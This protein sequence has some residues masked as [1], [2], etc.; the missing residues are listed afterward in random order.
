MAHRRDYHSPQRNLRHRPPRRKGIFHGF[1]VEDAESRAHLTLD[2]IV[3]GSDTAVNFEYDTFWEERRLLELVQDHLDWG[4]RTDTPF[5]S[6]YGDWGRAYREAERRVRAGKID[7]V[8]HEILINHGSEGEV[9]FRLVPKLMSTLGAEIPDKAA[10]NA[11]LEFICLH[12]IPRKF[13]IR[14][15][16]FE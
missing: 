11:E 7:V 13:I 3:S 14:T 6:V 16:E 12:F 5:I 10:H 9:Q 4:S 8:I 2:G 1:R 15:V